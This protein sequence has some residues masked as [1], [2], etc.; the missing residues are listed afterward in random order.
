M[1]ISFAAPMTEYK[2]VRI[3]G[4]EKLRQHLLN[5][6]FIEGESVMV[7]NK[8]GESVIIKLKGVSLAITTDLANKIY[9]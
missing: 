6:G 7:I 9:V 8:V 2:I 1:P 3:G 5:L 4:N